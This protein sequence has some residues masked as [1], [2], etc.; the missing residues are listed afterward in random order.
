MDLQA[1]KKE[2]A[3]NEIVSCLSA[4]GKVK[5]KRIY[6]RYPGRESLA[7][8]ASGKISPFLI[9]GPAPWKVL[10]S[11]SA[12]RAMVFDFKSLDGEKVNLVFLMGRA[13]RN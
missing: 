12:V 10:S 6:R 1:V 11:V 13:C 2:D 4:C 9:P 7:L 3:I 8:P 5:I